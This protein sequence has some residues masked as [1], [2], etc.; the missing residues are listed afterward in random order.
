[1]EKTSRS[2]IFDKQ[3]RKIIKLLIDKMYGRIS[4]AIDYKSE[5]DYDIGLEV[6]ILSKTGEFISGST[7]ER[8]VG[9]LPKEI[10]RGVSFKTLDVIS[11]YLEFKNTK[12]FLYRVEYLLKNPNKKLR[13]FR[14]ADIFKIHITKITLENKKELLLRYLPAIKSFEVIGGENIKFIVHD[15][16]ELSLLEIGEELMCKKTERI[17]NKTKKQLGPYKSGSQNMVIDISFIK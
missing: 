17:V 14:L 11:A 10:N 7:L 15:I 12:Q 2:Y 13:K 6:K 8:L 4:T 5:G 1:M 3:E 9:L 16:I